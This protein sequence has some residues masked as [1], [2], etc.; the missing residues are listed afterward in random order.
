MILALAGRRVDAA[1]AATP[2]FP[3][4][5]VEH[6]RNALRA[7][8]ERLAATVIVCSAACGADLIALAVASRLGLRH[9]I[10]LPIAAE[11]FRETSVVDRGVEWGAMFDELIGDA[12]QRGDLVVAVDIGEGDAA[13]AAANERILDEAVALG[14]TRAEEVRAVIVWNG[15]SRDERDLTDAFAAAARARGLPVVE[16]MTR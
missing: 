12:R 11:R 14:A 9:R 2:R 1:D 15:V 16:V 8:F 7:T 4:A 10:V 6:V 3:A 5:N 13:Y